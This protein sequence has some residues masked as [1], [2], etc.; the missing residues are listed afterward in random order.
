MSESESRSERREERDDSPLSSPRGYQA[1][2]G[3][4]DPAPMPLGGAQGVAARASARKALADEYERL[5]GQIPP[6]LT[7]EAL[8]AEV[9]RLHQ[10]AAD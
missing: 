4:G 9:E 7:V 8:R 1:V 10:A 3:Y 5:T 2:F 6:S